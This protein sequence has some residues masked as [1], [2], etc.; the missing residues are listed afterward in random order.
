MNR[1]ISN[2]QQCCC[3]CAVDSGLLRLD[4]ADGANSTKK[5]VLDYKPKR[6]HC[7]YLLAV[8]A[9][10]LLPQIQDHLFKY[11]SLQKSVLIVLSKT[12]QV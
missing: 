12:K 2:L 5:Q 9:Q 4:P 8:Y 11:H 1:N 3:R 10:K 6:K 7:N